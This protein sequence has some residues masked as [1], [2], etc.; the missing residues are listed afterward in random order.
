MVATVSHM[1]GHLFIINGD[2][3]KVAC[4]ALLIPTDSECKV[5]D[6]WLGFLESRGYTKPDSWKLG[7]V[8]LSASDAAPHAWLGNVGQPT[9]NSGFKAFA[10]TL[11]TFVDKAIAGL[12]AVSDGD[13]IYPWPKT[14]LAV[15]VVGSGRGGGRE[16]K[17]ELTRGL[18]KT[19][20]RLADSRDVDIILVTRGQKPYAAAQRARR[21]ALAGRTEDQTWR[22]GA[23]L[24]RQAQ[25]L[26]NAAIDE[27]L[28]L[29]IG[30]GVSAGAGLPLWGDLLMD[31]AKTESHWS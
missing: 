12:R 11:E 15:N 29:F 17:G 30:A 13:R 18:I 24:Q 26:A 22:L 8:F 16:K 2:L 28:V 27:H 4:D 10:P 19:L 31:I 6:H 20:T 9:N 1:G 7:D 14:R 25:I 23:E 3:T 21:L 5:E